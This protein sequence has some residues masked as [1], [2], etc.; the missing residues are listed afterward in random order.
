MQKKV[1]KERRRIFK[2]GNKVKED[3]PIQSYIMP[4]L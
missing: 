1:R 3:F 4:S 2:Y